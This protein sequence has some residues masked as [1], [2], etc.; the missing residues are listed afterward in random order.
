MQIQQISNSNNQT[1][2]GRVAIVGDLSAQPAKLVRKAA[3]N[4][5]PDLKILTMIFLLNRIIKTT[6]SN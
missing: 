2:Q 4:L 6:G 1:F 3:E 5:K